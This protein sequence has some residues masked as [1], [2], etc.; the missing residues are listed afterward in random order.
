MDGC[1]TRLCVDNQRAPI[2]CDAGSLD[3]DIEARFAELGVNG[4]VAGTHNV[5]TIA[6]KD[7]F[8]LGDLDP[9]GEIAKFGG[10]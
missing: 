6:G 5:K 3:R 9:F 7:I 1:M 8:A 4:S 2:G 10:I